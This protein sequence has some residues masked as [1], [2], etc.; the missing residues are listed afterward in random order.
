MNTHGLTRTNDAIREYW[1]LESLKRVFAGACAYAVSNP[2]V[3]DESTIDIYLDGKK[4]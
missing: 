3:V 2:H 1:R 4:L